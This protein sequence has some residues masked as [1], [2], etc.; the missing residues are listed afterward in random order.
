LAYEKAKYF[1]D[2]G[3]MTEASGEL[4]RALA[5]SEESYVHPDLLSLKDEIKES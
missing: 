4:E 3:K 2:Q 5:I 1:F